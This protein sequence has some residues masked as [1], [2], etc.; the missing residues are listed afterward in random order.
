M[1]WSRLKHL[2][3]ERFAPTIRS[4]V[5]LQQATELWRTGEMQK[6]LNGN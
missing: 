5:S 6:I 1:Q 4:R 3:E 2:V